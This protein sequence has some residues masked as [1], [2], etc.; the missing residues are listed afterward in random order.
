MA[1]RRKGRPINGVILV[2]KPNP[3]LVLTIRCKK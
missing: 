3:T 2:D 1:R